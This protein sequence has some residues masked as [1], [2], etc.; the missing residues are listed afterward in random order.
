MNT[1][2]HTP[3]EP[4]KMQIRLSSKL[5]MPIILCP[6]DEPPHKGELKHMSIYELREFFKHVRSFFD[7]YVQDAENGAPVRILSCYYEAPNPEKETYYLPVR[8]Q[9]GEPA[10]HVEADSPVAQYVLHADTLIQH[11][12]RE[13]WLPVSAITEESPIPFGAGQ[14]V[15]QKSPACT[16]KFRQPLWRFPRIPLPYTCMLTFERH[17]TLHLIVA[18]G[19]AEEYSLLLRGQNDPAP[20]HAPAP[21]GKTLHQKTKR[22][23]KKS[24]ALPHLPLPNSYQPPSSPCTWEEKQ[25]YLYELFQTGDSPACIFDDYLDAHEYPTLAKLVNYPTQ[26]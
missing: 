9:H 13:E 7:F 12:H 18:S 6:K 23:R 4:E 11:P 5:H 26:H 1:E 3:T 22:F 8:M 17:C 25:E 24:K 14:L 20:Q 15:M 2:N 21:Q 10:P 16:Q 19:Q